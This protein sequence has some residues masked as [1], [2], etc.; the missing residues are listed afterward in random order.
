MLAN[1]YGW[2]E[3]A[4]LDQ[5]Y[6]KLEELVYQIRLRSYLDVVRAFNV[7]ALA[8]DGVKEVD[9]NNFFEQLKPKRHSSISADKVNDVPGSMDK[10][11]I[12]EDMR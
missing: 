8:H 6:C 5:P 12:P 3:D 11:Y 7:Q 10:L 4:I 2:S 1:Q 9:I